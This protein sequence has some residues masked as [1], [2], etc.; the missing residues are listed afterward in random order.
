[1]ALQ[2]SGL[3]IMSC[4]IPADLEPYPRLVPKG[5][6]LDGVHQLRNDAAMSCPRTIW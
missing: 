4:N 1:M 2:L 3:A 5:V 6:A